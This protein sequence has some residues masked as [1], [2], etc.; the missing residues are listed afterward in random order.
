MQKKKISLHLSQL[1][2]VS[3]KLDRTGGQNSKSAHDVGYTSACCR[4]TNADG[5]PLRQ[6]VA[7]GCQEIQPHQHT[8]NCWQRLASL[9]DGL[10]V[11]KTRNAHQ[12][13][14]DVQN[15]D[16]GKLISVINMIVC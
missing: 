13:M 9:G 14:D 12:A 11:S 2:Y 15:L 8:Y 16:F 4:L 1:P 7:S 10:S 5:A 3:W 6:L